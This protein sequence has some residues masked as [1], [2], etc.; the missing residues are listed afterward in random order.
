MQKT[1]SNRDKLDLIDFKN[2]VPYGELVPE[3]GYILQWAL[4]MTAEEEMK[5]LK[6][7]DTVVILRGE[8]ETLE[9]AMEVVLTWA[10]A[11]LIPGKICYLG[12]G[13]NHPPLEIERRQVIYPAYKQ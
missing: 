5:W 11:Q 10:R 9:E 6:D 13:K 3:L 2:N 7:P 1:I 8:H 12:T 4:T